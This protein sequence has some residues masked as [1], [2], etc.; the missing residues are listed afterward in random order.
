MHKTQSIAE[1][2]GNAISFGDIVINQNMRKTL[3]IPE[4]YW[5]NSVFDNDDGMAL[6]EK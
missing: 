3:L 5:T 6:K 4:K 2:D 1:V